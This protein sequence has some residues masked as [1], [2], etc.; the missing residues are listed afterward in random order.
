MTLTITWWMIPTFITIVA[1]GWALLYND[2]ATGL[3]TGMMNLFLLIP[4]LFVSMIVWIIAAII[5]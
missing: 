4:A 1:I 5:K 3:G 2:G